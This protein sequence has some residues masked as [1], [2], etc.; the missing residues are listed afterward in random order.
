MTGRPVAGAPRA[1]R[2]PDITRQTLDNGLGLW[3]VPLPERELVSVQLLTDA[4]AAAEDEPQGGIASL[5]AQ[6]LVTGTQR[7]DAAAFAEAAEA[8]GIDVGSE[9]SWD[10]A[11]ASFSALA[12][13][14]EAGI[15]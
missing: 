15:G 11:R 13:H 4:G 9:S 14:L 10:S 2:F 5:T 1:Y 3:L 8:L 12:E 7:L 6:A